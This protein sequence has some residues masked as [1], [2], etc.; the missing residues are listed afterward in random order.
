MDL[1]AL[2]TSRVMSEYWTLRILTFMMDNAKALL[3]LQHFVERSKE[4]PIFGVPKNSSAGLPSFSP[5]PGSSCR[6]SLVLFDSLF[7]NIVS[8]GLL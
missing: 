4:P 8:T 3:H 6:V 7:F 5:L 1:P 2:I